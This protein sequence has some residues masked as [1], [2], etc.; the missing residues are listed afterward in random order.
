[1]RFRSVAFVA[2]SVLLLSSPLRAEDLR[3]D[4]GGVS[5]P[6]PEGWTRRTA[7]LGATTLLALE[8]SDPGVAASEPVPTIVVNS[9]DAQAMNEEK[10]FQQTR[11]YL[12]NPGEVLERSS[13]RYL[14]VDF[15]YTS[16]DASGS[17]ALKSRLYAALREKKL[18]YFILTTKAETFER[19]ARAIDAVV[20]GAKF[21]KPVPKPAPTAP[22]A[23]PPATPPPVEKTP[24]KPP[25]ASGEEGQRPPEK[26]PPR[27]A[28]S[29]ATPPA[30]S[31]TSDT[32][33]GETPPG[34]APADEPLARGPTTSPKLPEPQGPKATRPAA[35]TK[36]A[37]PR[38]TALVRTNSSDETRLD[39]SGNADGAAVGSMTAS[40]IRRSGT[41]NLLG[42]KTLIANDGELESDG[43]LAQNLV[44]PAATKPWCSSPS[45][46]AGRSKRFTFE[47]PKA[48][49]VARVTLDAGVPEEAGFEGSAAKDIVIRGSQA[50]AAGPW[51]ELARA[52]L[53]K[54][55]NDQSV[56]LPVNETRWLRVDV[57]SNYGHPTLTQL[58]KVRA[59]AA[60]T[61]AAPR[62]TPAA[63]VTATGEGPFR[64]ERLRLSRERNGTPLEP[65]V[66]SA[67]DVFWVYFKPR[68]LRLDAKGEYGLEVDLRLEDADGNEKL[69]SPR[70]VDHRAKPPRAPLSPFVSLKVELP[71]DF[72][73]GA[74]AVTLN[75]R[76]KNAGTE[77]KERVPFEVKKGR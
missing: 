41:V 39:A 31:A 65:A 9:L 35:P 28:G 50:S 77:L 36:P 14:R 6:T 3:S 40:T 61:T 56:D 73:A 69:F 74:Y 71:G 15:A 53:E 1:M 54:G 2:L 27:K 76:D 42:P 18:Y 13:G 70:V 19:D 4:E 44:D 16:N 5:I 58:M 26:N 25:S 38:D 29:D 75:V 32:K 22:A 20:D 23:P 55:K 59:F 67:G 30:R 52:T 17:H 60:E 66:F 45:S 8:R 72:P 46:P 49:D 37:P 21:F 34:P 33:P 11:E 64:V 12:P 57:L 68:A 7:K 63:P 51:V 24:S 62:E 47:L 10:A 43:R 48:I